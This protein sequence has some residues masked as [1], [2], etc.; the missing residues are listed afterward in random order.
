M[1]S[2]AG[3]ISSVERVQALESGRLGFISDQERAFMRFTYPAWAS[4]FSPVKWDANTHYTVT[5]DCCGDSI[6]YT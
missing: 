4:A 6:I 1:R 2:Q 5:L 3:G